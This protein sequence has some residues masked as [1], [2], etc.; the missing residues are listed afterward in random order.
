MTTYNYSCQ[1]DKFDTNIDFK[2]FDKKEN[3]LIQIF[4]GEDKKTLKYLTELLT[5]NIPQAICIGATTDGEMNN[6][7]VSTNKS[8]VSISIFEHTFLKIAY[9]KGHDSFNNGLNIAKKIITKNTKLIITFTDA[10]FN[11]GEEYLKG[12]E[13]FDNSIM[14]CGGMAGDNGKFLQTYVSYGTNVLESGCVAVSL[15]SDVL[16][17]VN[18][19]K[20]DWLPIGIEHTI[21]KVI[22]NRLYEISGMKATDFYE[23]Y[24][25]SASLH[26][27]FPL[28]THRNGIPIARALLTKYDDGSLGCGGNL[29]KGDKV[30]LGFANSELIKQAPFKYLKN[31]NNYQAETFFIYSCMARR[32]YMQDLINIEIQP[33]SLIAPTAGFFTYAE[34]F[35]K[36]GHNELMNQTITI[37]GLSENP[38]NKV[39]KNK[40]KIV[41][42]KPTDYAKTITSLTN[43]VQQSAKDYEQQAQK[44]ENEKNYSENILQNQ[45]TFLNQ[46]VHET[47]TPLAVI[48]S[49]IELFEMEYGKNEYMSNVEIAMKNI[50]SIYEDLS[51]LVKK[52]QI[53]YKIQQL[54]LIDF[55]RSRAYFFETI[56]NQKNCKFII[57][58]NQSELLISF[59]IDK[60]QRIIDNNLSNAIKYSY[61]NKDIFLSILK[62]ENGF[63]FIVSSHSNMI[64]N[65]NKIFEEYY[66]EEQ[67]KEGFGIGLNLVKR[68]CDEESI[69]VL[70]ESNLD[71]T[72]F[73]YIFKGNI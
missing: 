69:D 51:Y 20:F 19:S 54:D 50:Y 72:S 37:V 33:F 52:D 1:Y 60:L 7:I 15:N 43:L 27:Q 34:F 29:Y 49:N 5:Q 6:N 11:N 3:V 40:N 32:R 61:E 25:G 64:Q 12:I 46:T 13:K 24:L 58:I 59:N 66:R 41:E 65:P 71:K 18:D 10:T 70:V 14:V 55:I 21:D 38:I 28:I 68:I 73:T 48:M 26:T 36:D 39:I 17:V 9:I 2:I 56:A 16:E 23:K 67:S 63:K 35:H 53:T 45:K 30:K 4:C 42:H 44:L 8:V 31:I 22:G 57:D 62:I 47:N